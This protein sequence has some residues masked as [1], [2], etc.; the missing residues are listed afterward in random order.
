MTKYIFILGREPVLSVAEINSQLIKNNLSATWLAITQTYVLLA[1]DLPADFFDNLAGSVKLAEYVDKV[2]GDRPTVEKVI[3]DFLK[4]IISSSYLFGFSWYGRRPP[5]WLNLAGLSLKKEFKQSGARARLVVSREADLSSVVVEKN[6]LLPPTGYDFI[7]LPQADGSLIIGRTI[8]VQDFAAWS[9]RDYGRPARQAKVGMLPPKLARLM[10]NLSLADKQ[11][12]LLDPFCGS[13]TV[14]QEAAS[15]GYL[16]LWGSDIDQRG[17]DRT[18]SNLEWLKKDCLDKLFTWQLQAV[19]VRQL[20]NFIKQQTFGAVVTEPYLG[21][22]LS[23][24]ESTAEL[25][26][27]QVELTQFYATTLK[28]LYSALQPGARLVMVWP[29]WRLREEKIF[30]PL[31]DKVK[32]YGFKI[33]NL[34]PKEAPVGWLNNRGSYIYHR[35]DQ[36]LAREIWVFRK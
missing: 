36:R 4:K 32:S 21:P 9:K 26:N 28:I 25:K 27:I 5:K 23:G 3:R 10:V 35:P 8:K 17:I 31:V 33:E 18:N 11:Q 13:G 29:S 14:L 24:H 12:A 22:P 6:K 16:K 34:L 1:A 30:L 20:P 7:F 2:A 19:D 15:L